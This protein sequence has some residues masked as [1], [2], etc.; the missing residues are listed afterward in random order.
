MQGRTQP[1]P[2]HQMICHTWHWFKSA[3]IFNLPSTWSIRP[4]C[5]SL[6]WSTAS[7]TGIECWF[8]IL[9]VDRHRAPQSTI[10]NTKDEF[11]STVSHNTLSHHIQMFTWNR[12][13]LRCCRVADMRQRKA[14]V[15]LLWNANETGQFLSCASDK[16]SR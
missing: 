10:E 3:P 16:I 7:I 11:Q 4:F 9:L 5:V 14:N 15:S 13:M 6:L 1:W 2:Q 8:P 12:V